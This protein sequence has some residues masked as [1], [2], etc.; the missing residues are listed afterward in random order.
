[1][2]CENVYFL[3]SSLPGVLYNFFSKWNQHNLD[4]ASLTLYK[5][6]CSH[7]VDKNVK[8][9]HKNVLSDLSERHIR[10]NIDDIERKKR[11]LA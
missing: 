6:M 7:H 11:C 4:L 5:L 9:I 3:M 2:H 8:I 1:M 10:L